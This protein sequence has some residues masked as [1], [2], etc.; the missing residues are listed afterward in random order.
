MNS[1]PT[2]KK[3]VIVAGEASGDLHAANL[4]KNLHEKCPGSYYISAIGGK[5]LASTQV[6]M[7]NYLAN[8]GVTGYTEV[9]RHFKTIKDAFT[10]ITNHLKTTKPDLLI[11]VDYPGFNLRLAKYAKEKLG[12]RI[13]YYISP[14][15]WAWKAKRIH[16]IKK[17]V[18]H[19]A[20]ILPF[21]KTIYD[22][23][24]IPCNFVGHPLL[25]HLI[26][27]SPTDSRLKL[28]LPLDQKIVALLPGSRSNEVKRH[29]PVMIE[30]ALLMLGQDPT[31]QFVMPVAHTLS[32][33]EINACAQQPHLPLRFINEQAQRVMNASDAVVVASG[34]A[35]LECALLL[36]PMCI[37]YKTS[38]ITSIIASLVLKVKYIGLCNLIANRMIVPELLQDDCTPQSICDLTLAY[39]TNSTQTLST[40][41]QLETVKTSLEN[42]HADARLEEIVSKLTYQ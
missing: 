8:F 20:V 19:M 32:Q 25:Q 13:L 37:I 21:E 11:L 42:S 39:L 5:H 6:E 31:L 10:L 34:T 38:L 12:I 36:K 29:L 24:Q 17:Y 33:D 4:V 22:Q 16:T 1:Q 18:D 26:K 30:A 3:I 7:L 40:I 15:I 23:S 28:Q 2:K 9:L 41:H 35:S 14:Q 27:E